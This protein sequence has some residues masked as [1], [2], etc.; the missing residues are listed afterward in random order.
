MGVMPSCR[1]GGHGLMLR[2]LLAVDVT[3][4]VP[5]QPTMI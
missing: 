2:D 5:A 4:L 3:L 1:A